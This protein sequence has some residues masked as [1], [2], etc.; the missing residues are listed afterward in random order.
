MDRMDDSGQII[1]GSAPVLILRF[2]L[3]AASDKFTYTGRGKRVFR[4]LAEGL[5]AGANT[6]FGRSTATQSD[7]GRVQEDIL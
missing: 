7:G 5:V 1:P 6:M 3:S 2:L 4:L